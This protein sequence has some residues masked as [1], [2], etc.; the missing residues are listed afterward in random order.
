M[1]Y[2]FIV[3]HSWIFDFFWFL[4][5]NFETLRNPLYLRQAG[6]KGL[7]RTYIEST[8]YGTSYIVY[9]DTSL[10]VTKRDYVSYYRKYETKNGMTYI[11]YRKDP[12]NLDKFEPLPNLLSSLDLRHPPGHILQNLL[13]FLI[14]W[15]SALQ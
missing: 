5:T 12:P 4:L 6:I 3:P 9:R 14:F 11:S 7:H 10:K 13:F 8:Y 15:I 2:A 1:S